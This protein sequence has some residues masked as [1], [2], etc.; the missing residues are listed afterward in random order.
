MFEEADLIFSYSRADAIADGVLIDVS[1]RAK[2]LGYRIPVALSRGLYDAV[3]DGAS[4]ETEISAG[5]DLLL[6]ALRDSIAGSPGAGDRLDFAI[7]APSLAH[8]VL[9]LCAA[10]AIRPHQS[11][12]S[13]FVTK[14]D[15]RFVS[16]LPLNGNPSS[17]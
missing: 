14:T 3:T 4:D 17:S 6:I 5:V 12:Q 15:I 1:S 7:K 2:T 8:R 11:S 16:W 10:P 9:G 13:C